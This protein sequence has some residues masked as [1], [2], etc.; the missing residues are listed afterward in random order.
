MKILLVIPSHPHLRVWQP[1]NFWR[2]ALVKLGHK[3]KLFYLPRHG[4]KLFTTWQL[5]RTINKLKPNEIFFSAGKDAVYPIKQTIFFTGVS[6]SMLS[7]DEQI[8]GDSSKLV[9]TNDPAHIRDWPKAICLPISAIDPDFH[10]RLKPVAKYTND[11]CFIGGLL[12]KRQRLFIKLLASGI[13]LKLYGTLPDNF[14]SPSLKSFYR[15]PVWGKAVAQIYS[16]CKIALNP[17]PSHLPHGYNLR[18]FEI[19]GCGAFQLAFKTNQSASAIIASI[20][21]Y[22]GHDAVRQKIAESDYVSTRRD[23]TYTKRFAR[24]LRLLAPVPAHS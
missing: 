23:H 16:S 15:G 8:I 4:L 2:R 6:R 24:L 5:N 11:V 22:L 3:V 14:L 7:R 18:S 20:N 9:V 1:Q 21:Y 17:F 12:L 13:N 19:P 10:K